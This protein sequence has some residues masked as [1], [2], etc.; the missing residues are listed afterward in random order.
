MNLDPRREID[1]QT[2]RRRFGHFIGLRGCE[3]PVQSV[4][5]GVPWVYEPELEPRESCCD[6]LAVDSSMGVDESETVDQMLGR[7]QRDWDEALAL[8]GEE[9]RLGLGFKR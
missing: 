4:S 5:Q 7:M 6:E 3:S 2:K 8:A 9:E 1:L